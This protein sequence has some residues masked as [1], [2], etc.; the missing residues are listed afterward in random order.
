M[1]AGVKFSKR[2]LSEIGRMFRLWHAFTEGLVDRHTLV[3]KS[4]P[5]RAR[6]SNCLQIYELSGDP[7]VARTALG[8]LKHWNHLFTFLE[9][10]GVEPTNNSAERGIRPAVQWRKICFGINPRPD[11]SSLQGCLRPPERAFFKIKTPLSS[12]SIPSLL[13]DLGYQHL[14]Y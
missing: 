14:L 3:L 6:M 2:I 11:K 5:I 1:A 9:H 10:E 13:I 8:L 4:V 7:D 12:W